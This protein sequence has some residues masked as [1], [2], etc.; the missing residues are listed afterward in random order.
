VVGGGGEE[1]ERED[2]FEVTL[3]LSEFTLESLTLLLH[4]PLAELGFG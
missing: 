2:L 4:A 3:L 1:R